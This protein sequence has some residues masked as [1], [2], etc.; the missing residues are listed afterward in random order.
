MVSLVFVFVDHCFGSFFQ[1][2]LVVVV[3]IWVATGLKAGRVD[4]EH[5]WGV[6]A[7]SC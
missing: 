1:A 5:G 2:V 3:H 6:S 7:R 4:V